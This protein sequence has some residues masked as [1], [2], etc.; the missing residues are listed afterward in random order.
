MQYAMNSSCTCLNKMIGMYVGAKFV[1]VPVISVVVYTQDI[2]GK[3]TFT[4]R[5]S[6]QSLDVQQQPAC[7]VL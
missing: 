6:V 1:K 3:I 7:P 2:L 4:R 5:L